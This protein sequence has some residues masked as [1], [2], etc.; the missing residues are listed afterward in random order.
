MTTSVDTKAQDAGAAD[1]VKLAVAILLVIAGV[2]GY[3][4]LG[5]QPAWLRWLAGAAGARLRGGGGLLRSR[6][7]AGVATLARGRGGHRARGGRG[8]LFEVRHGPEAIHGRFPRRV[9][10]DGVP[11]PAGDGNDHAGGVRLPARCRHFLLGP[12]SRA[13]LGNARV[14]RTRE[15]IVALRW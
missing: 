13:R 5:N 15:L 14:D 4:V 7:S 12:R 1:T 6:Q 3:Y 9:A 11:E 2:A 10:Q 8:R